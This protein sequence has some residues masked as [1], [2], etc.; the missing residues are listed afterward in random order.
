M[1]IVFLLEHHCTAMPDCASAYGVAKLVDVQHLPG[2]ANGAVFVID[3]V[4]MRL[5]LPALPVW[6]ERLQAE[7]R[8][9]HLMMDNDFESDPA[10]VILQLATWH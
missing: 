10:T 6:R 5:Q 8:G 3:I 4:N 7:R 1:T 9:E 2:G